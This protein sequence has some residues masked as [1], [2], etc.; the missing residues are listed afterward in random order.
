MPMTPAPEDVFTI[1]PPPGLLLDQAGRF[2]V[3]LLGPVGGHHAGTLAGERQR[4]R[5]AD[6]AR[7]PGHESS[8]PCETSLLVRR[9]CL[10]LFVLPASRRS[11]DVSATSIAP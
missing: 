7:G 2:L 5:A 11:W 9:H 4:R 10:P 8:L 6:A 3:A 1:A